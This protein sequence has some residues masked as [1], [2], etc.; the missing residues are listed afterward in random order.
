MKYYANQAEKAQRLTA[1]RH[2]QKEEKEGPEITA[3]R[4]AV[5]EPPDCF[6]HENARLF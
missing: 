1:T 5:K 4:A 2:A 6:S 3:M